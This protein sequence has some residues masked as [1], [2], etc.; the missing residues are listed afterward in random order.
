MYPHTNRIGSFD[1]YDSGGHGLC[2]YFPGPW[3]V[4]SQTM[5]TLNPINVEVKTI[6]AYYWHDQ[7]PISSKKFTKMICEDTNH[8]WREL[9]PPYQELGWLC[10]EVG[11]GT[12]E[13]GGRVYSLNY[14]KNNQFD[15][16]WKRKLSYK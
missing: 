9:K 13:E 5:Y 8:G 15:I 1:R 6:C 7:T 4:L 12:P 3:L 16:R 11:G 14:F 2:P 10:S